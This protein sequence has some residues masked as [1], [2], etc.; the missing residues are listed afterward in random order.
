LLPQD[1]RRYM[2]GSIRFVAQALVSSGD[3]WLDA[4]PEIQ[5]IQPDIYAVNEDGD[6]GGKREYCARMGIEYLVLK[7]VP[8]PGLPERSSTHLR[9]F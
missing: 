5:K 1:E 6:K 2:A 4:E 9:G 8:A 7:R 3:G